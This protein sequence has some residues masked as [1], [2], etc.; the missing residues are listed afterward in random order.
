MLISARRLELLLLVGYGARLLYDPSC[1][2]QP[3]DVRCIAGLLVSNRRLCCIL[4]PCLVLPLV[5][6][7]RGRS[8]QISPT[9]AN[10]YL[11]VPGERLLLAYSD[12]AL[13]L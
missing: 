10:R 4:I 8:T 6:L 2:H 13:A 9:N 1:V 12:L 7:E 5:S 11:L 3:S